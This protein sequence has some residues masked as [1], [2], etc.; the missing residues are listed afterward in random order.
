LWE[1]DE[2]CGTYIVV[3]LSYGNA[4]DSYLFAPYIVYQIDQRNF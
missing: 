4:A 2:L 1:G 3:K